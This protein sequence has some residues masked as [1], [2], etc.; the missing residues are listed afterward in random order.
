MNLSV[1]NRMDEDKNNN[2]M[3][4]AKGEIWDREKVM[5]AVVTPRCALF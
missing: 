1:P 4:K 5:R 2:K 3:E